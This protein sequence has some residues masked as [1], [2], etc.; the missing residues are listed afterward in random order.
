MKI[1]FFIPFILFAPF[2]NKGNSFPNQPPYPQP[3]KKRLFNSFQ[4][5]D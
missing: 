3:K 1:F 2:Q 4:I 5:I